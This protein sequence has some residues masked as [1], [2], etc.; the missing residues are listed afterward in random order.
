MGLLFNTLLAGS[1]I[2]MANKVAYRLFFS[3]KRDIAVKNLHK[4]ARF[5]KWYYSPYGK[6]NWFCPV[7]SEN[8]SI[9]PTDVIL[10]YVDLRLWKADETRAL[11][12]YAAH[13]QLNNI[14]NNYGLKVG[15][16]QEM[17]FREFKESLKGISES[18]E[19]GVFGIRV[20]LWQVCYYREYR[21]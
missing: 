1:L 12:P 2:V 4:N 6:L 16:I 21:D 7:E 19:K 5:L 17:K 20:S 15:Y 10:D 18:V 8:H 3:Q 13:E 9:N 14:L 11:R